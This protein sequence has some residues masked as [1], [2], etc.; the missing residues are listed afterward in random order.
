MNKQN[1]FDHLQGLETL[2]YMVIYEKS[3]H[4]F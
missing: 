1:P 4:F 3:N 2:K